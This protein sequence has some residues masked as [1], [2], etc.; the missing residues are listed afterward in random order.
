MDES[1]EKMYDFA[2]GID[3]EL[4]FDPQAARSLQ[5]GFSAQ[6]ANEED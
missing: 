5:I 2:I 6:L 4:Y 1:S 3:R